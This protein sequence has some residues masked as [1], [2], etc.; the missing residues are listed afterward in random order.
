MDVLS[1]ITALASVGS[2]VYFIALSKPKSCKNAVRRWEKT[3]DIVAHGQRYQGS[4][5]VALFNFYSEKSGFIGYKSKTLYKTPSGRYFEIDLLCE[6]GSVVSWQLDIIEPEDAAAFL[7]LI[8]VD[9]NTAAELQV[10]S[11]ASK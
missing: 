11:Q 2:A 5:A 9:D 8:G 6:L 3:F 1:L 4:R 7:S 10:K